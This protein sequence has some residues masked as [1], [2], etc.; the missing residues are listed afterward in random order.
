MSL[1]FERRGTGEPLLLVHSLGGSKVVWRPVI[2]RLSAERDVIAV[3]MPGFGRSPAPAGFVPS[4]ANLARALVA[5]CAEQGVDRPHVVGNSLGGWVALEMAKLGRAASVCAISPA[6]LWR[7][8]LGRR[9]YERQ[10][11]GRRIRPLVSALLRSRRGR[12]WLLGWNF[13]RPDAVPAADATEM[14]QQYLA[15]PSYPEA[16]RMMREGAFE[17]GGLVQVPVTIAWGEGDRVVG[18][19][20]SS[21]LPPGVKVAVRPGWGHTP[22]WDDP[23]GVA[24]LILEAS[25]G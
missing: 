21:R 8:P 23:E 9:R 5:F 25:S 10:A 7:H 3:D 19:P 24:E 13:A 1:S 11:L 12:A 2:E 18:H 15:A 4:A 22:T 16:N 20:S 6:G 14:A 17:H